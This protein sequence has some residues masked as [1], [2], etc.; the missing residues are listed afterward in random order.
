MTPI[1]RALLIHLI[2][3][4][5]KDI[6]IVSNEVADRPPKRKEEEGGWQIQYDDHL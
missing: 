1:I 2:G 3:A 4:E 6:E 5:A